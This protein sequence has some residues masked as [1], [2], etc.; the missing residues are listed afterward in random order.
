MN[1]E[2]RHAHRGPVQRRSPKARHRRHLDCGSSYWPMRSQAPHPP[3]GGSF[4]GGQGGAPGCAALAWQAGSS[5]A[6][7]V[8]AWSPSGRTEEQDVRQ[9]ATTIMAS[10]RLGPIGEAPRFA[11]NLAH[12]GRL[13]MGSDADAAA[14]GISGWRS[15]SRVS[16]FHPPTT[17][18]N[19][20]RRWARIQASFSSSASLP[21]AIRISRRRACAAGDA[22]PSSSDSSFCAR[23]KVTSAS[24]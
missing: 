2:G 15:T 12:R 3:G 8:A 11:G 23:V 24:R 22:S 6:V 14:G 20:L 5:D 16:K 21:T 4:G 1:E 18:S 9:S 19:G 7:L 17:G 13:Q 10:G